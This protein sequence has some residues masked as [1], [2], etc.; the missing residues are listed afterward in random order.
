M[1]AAPN[2]YLGCN[3]DGGSRWSVGGCKHKLFPHQLEKN[4]G[5][6]LENI[7]KKKNLR[8]E[9]NPGVKYYLIIGRDVRCLNL[10]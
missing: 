5:P 3:G 9:K 8:V 4:I 2:V 10:K 1:P 7:Y 6:H